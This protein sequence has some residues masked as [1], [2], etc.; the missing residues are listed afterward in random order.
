MALVTLAQTKRHLRI[1]TETTDPLSE[2]DEDLTLKMGQAE[3]LILDYL[4]GGDAAWTDETTVPPVVQAA[5]LVQVAELW[6]F[7]GDDD[8]YAGITQVTHLPGQLSLY[9]VNLLRRY[10]DPALA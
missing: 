2:E 5:L 1:E 3:A 6:R 8:Q 10:R 9:V 4:E 7:R